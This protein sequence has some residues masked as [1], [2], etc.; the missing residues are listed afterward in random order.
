VPLGSEVIV[1]GQREVE[2]AFMQVRRE[3]FI[4]MKPALL[5]IGGSV[6][7][8]AHSRADDEIT[9]IGGP[10]SEFRI[11]ATV[12]GIYVAPKR[13]RGGGNRRPNLAGLLRNVMQEA[14]DA[15]QERVVVELGQLVDLAGARAGL[16]GI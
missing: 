15:N 9:N 2:A 1:K 10:W 13:R 16:I 7:A 3:T 11:G 4:G 5:Q 6:R 12:K 14:V 8:D